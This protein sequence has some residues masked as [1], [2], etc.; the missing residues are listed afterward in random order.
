VADPTEGCIR[1]T[2]HAERCTLQAQ[3]GAGR[4]IPTPVLLTDPGTAANASPDGLPDA[5]MSSSDPRTA[6]AE[7]AIHFQSP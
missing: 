2:L 6:H 4:A 3:E 1:V 5:E 7:I